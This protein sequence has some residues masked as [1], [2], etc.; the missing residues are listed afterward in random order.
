MLTKKWL[1]TCTT[2][3]FNCRGA[4]NPCQLSAARI[5]DLGTEGLLGPVR[6]LEGNEL[7]KV[8]RYMTLSHCWGGLAIPQLT[9]KTHK[10]FRERMNSKAFPRTF[11]DAITITRLL[12]IRYLWIDSLCIVQDDYRDWEEQARQMGQIYSHAYCN[13]AATAAK[14]GRDGLLQFLARHPQAL[15][16]LDVCIP[17]MG[18]IK[19]QQVSGTDHGLQYPQRNEDWN[20]MDPGFYRCVDPFLWRREITE[21]P[22][23]LRAWAVQ[24]RLLAPRVIHFGRTQIFWVGMPDI[25]LGFNWRGAFWFAKLIGSIYRESMQHVIIASNAD[26]DNL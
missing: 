3:H 25:Y 6:V 8:L 16:P 14:D 19:D 15:M 24:E 4:S 12:G 7:P 10:R 9:R 26:Y 18:Q 1:H 2:T 17:N 11:R 23:G 21:S 13:L 22:L 5:L 20:G